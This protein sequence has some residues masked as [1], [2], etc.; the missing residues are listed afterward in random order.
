MIV[1]IL[2][3]ALASLMG[4]VLTIG[5]LTLSI[6]SYFYSLGYI[7]EGL[8]FTI[9]GTII[10]LIIMIASS[11]GKTFMTFN[12]VF[13]SQVKMNQTLISE[14][15][16]KKTNNPNIDSILSSLMPGNITITDMET[17]ETSSS[18]FPIGEEDSLKKINDMISKAMRS[19][20]KKEN[21]EDMNIFELEKELAKALKK[22]DFEKAGE[23]NILLKA[24][25]DPPEEKED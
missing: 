6:M 2:L 24:K 17:G 16:N 3:I 23:I 4:I 9:L 15:I 20:K 10:F 25:K 8:V 12:K 7:F 21:L 18:S 11:V 19:G 22:D 5:G 1:N 14:L 13:T